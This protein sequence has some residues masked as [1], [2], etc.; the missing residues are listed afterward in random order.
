MTSHPLSL[1]DDYEGIA[2]RQYL[3][4]CTHNGGHTGPK[5]VN[6]CF[7]FEAERLRGALPLP[8]YTLSLL[9]RIRARNGRGMARPSL[10]H[11]TRSE[12]LLG[13]SDLDGESKKQEA[14]TAFLCAYE[15]ASWLMKCGHCDASV[16]SR[17]NLLCLCQARR[18]TS[19]A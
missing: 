4:I 12:P 11:L 16:A 19:S 10:A 6:S 15:A 13:D 2:L 7:F 1:G 8:R 14:I 5:A 3:S 17:A 9:L 18:S